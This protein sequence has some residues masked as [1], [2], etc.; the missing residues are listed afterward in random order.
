MA[1]G[2]KEKREKTKILG[3]FQ[4]EAEYICPKQGK[5]KDYHL[6]SIG[7]SIGTILV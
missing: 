5:I 6:I 1:Y 4:N 3:F 2:T 7:Y